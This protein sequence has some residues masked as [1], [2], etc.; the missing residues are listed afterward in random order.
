MASKTIRWENIHFGEVAEFRNGLNFTKDSFGNGVKVI[1]VSDFQDYTVP[2]YNEI[3]E[4]NPEGVV[5]EEDLLQEGDILFVRSNGNRELIGRSLFIQG[6]TEAVS[7]SGF[8]I[9]ARIKS[10]KAFPRFFAYLF[11]TQLVRRTL[12]AFGGG[13]NI[14]NLN[15]KILQSLEVPLP[16][17]DTQRK[18]AAILSAY[19]DLIE[20]NLRR[21]K[22]LEEMAQNLYREWFVKFRFPGHQH[23]RF[24]DS[25]LGRIPVGWEV[26]NLGEQ[27]TALESGKRPKGGATD[28]QSGVPSVG[29]ENVLGIGRHNFQNEKYVSREFFESMK[30]GVVND[31]DVALYKDGAYIGKSSYFRNGFPH[32]EFCVNEHVF[33]LRTDGKR[34]TQNSLYLWLQETDTVSALRATNANA[35]QPGINQSGVSGLS[36]VLPAEKVVQDFDQLVDSHLAM[37]VSLAKRNQALRRTR[38]L[39]LPRLISGEVDVSELDITISEEAS[40]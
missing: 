14:N 27:L 36:V 24:V 38:D 17:I 33:L 22:I 35:A 25:P 16:P 4:I 30:K 28:E 21:I 34:I 11:R 26:K 23:T 31:G 20:N 39:L 15:Q 19:D 29:A 6:L 37:I 1:G 7:H 5:K 32:T 18:I 8:T 40:L 3:P 2:R 10:E 13:T 12:S 9:R